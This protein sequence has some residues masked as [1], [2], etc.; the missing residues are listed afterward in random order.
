M[1]PGHVSVGDS[2]WSGR[3]VE[4]VWSTGTPVSRDGHGHPAPSLMLG[5]PTGGRAGA[6]VLGHVCISLMTV[7][8]GPLIVCIDVKGLLKS[9]AHFPIWWR[10]LSEFWGFF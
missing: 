3:L 9:S 4:G 1:G 2:A 5:L 8:L 10:F 7:D 6:R